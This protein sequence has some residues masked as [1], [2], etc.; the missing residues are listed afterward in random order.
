ML[1]VIDSSE[2]ERLNI[3]KD[4]IQDLLKEPLLKKRN[5]PIVFILNKQDKV[6]ALEKE[7]LIEALGLDSMKKS[8]RK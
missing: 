6:N 3:T 2:S 4:I 5:T 1:F 7:V 8:M